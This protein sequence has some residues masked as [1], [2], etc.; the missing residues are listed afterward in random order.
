MTATATAAVEEVKLNQ[1]IV[2]LIAQL[3]CHKMNL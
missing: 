1:I 2:L 3:T